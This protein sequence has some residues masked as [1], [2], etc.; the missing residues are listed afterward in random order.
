MI[1]R[2]FSMERR[3]PDR[4]LGFQKPAHKSL[5]RMPAVASFFNV[6]LAL[7]VSQF[8]LR[9]YPGFYASR[10]GEFSNPAELLQLLHHAKADIPDHGIGCFL[11]TEN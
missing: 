1:L 4:P 3:S 9:H 6:A 8:E 10:I 2:A 7:V 5:Y 11:P